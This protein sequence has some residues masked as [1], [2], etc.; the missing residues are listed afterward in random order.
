LKKLVLNT[1][2]SLYKPIE[3]EIDDKAYSCRK[4]TKDVIDKIFKFSQ[5]AQDGDVNAPYEQ[6]HFAFNIPLK[7]LYELHI[8]E[9][10]DINN[11]IIEAIVHPT[12]VEPE[13]EKNVKGPGDKS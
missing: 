8:K 3:I 1:T 5:K 12:K 6:A 9:V 10:G 2:K 13:E 7:I 11:K 4:L